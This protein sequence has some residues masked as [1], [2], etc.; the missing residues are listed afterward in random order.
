M[1]DEKQP[2]LSDLPET[3]RSPTIVLQQPSKADKWLSRLLL[4]GLIASVLVN[5]SLYNSYQDYFAS[6]AG[7]TERFHSGDAGAEEKIAVIRVRGTIMPPFT[8]RILSS[9]EKAGDDADVKGVLLVIDSP[10]GLVADSHQIYHELQKLQTGEKK[11]PIYVAMQRMAASG[12]YY[13]AMGA[14]EGAPIYVEPTTW[15]GSIGVIIPRYDLSELAAE[16]KVKSDPLK[17]G[18]FKDALS[19]FR[20]LTADERTVWN[21]IL[22]DAF[23]RFIG[24]IAENRKTLDEP[25]VRK[26][27]T[28]Q[29]YTANQAL[30]N[31]LV[32]KIGY[33]ED[34]LSDL[35][36]ELKLDEVRIVTYQ[37]PQ[38]LLD[39]FVGSVEAEEP[40][41][42]W[43]A[44]LDTTVPRAM[45]FC[46][47]APG[48]PGW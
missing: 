43:K 9:I 1:S 19:P 7:P 4:I 42:K 28:G 47:W 13:I 5:V 14:G 6:A 38:T 35:Q 29:I 25:A 16:W 23:G 31:G 32:D 33:E 24:V 37:H 45:Y 17:T 18:P 15:T 39:L 8:S 21:E 46:S 36:E 48:V 34:A 2:Q 12:G 44:L 22:D 20:E 40:G 41:A 30:A 27:A 10:G 3:T 11:K 26:L